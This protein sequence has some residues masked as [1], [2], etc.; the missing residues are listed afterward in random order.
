MRVYSVFK[1]S[2][3]A[4]GYPPGLIVTRFFKPLS[5]PSGFQSDSWY[6]AIKQKIEFILAAVSESDGR[7]IIASDTD[8]QFFKPFASLDFSAVLRSTGVDILFMREAGSDPV[9]VNAGFAVIRCTPAVAGLYRR[10]LS[11]IESERLPY[12]D[13]DVLNTEW[14]AGSVSIGVIPEDSVIWGEKLPAQP[15]Q[16]WFHH[17]VCCRT[18]S[19][20]LRQFA[21]VRLKVERSELEVEA[22]RARARSGYGRR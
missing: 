12:S 3:L 22:G 13:Q 2:L 1:S 6:H 7:V 17:A 14:R 15:F 5:G 4:I 10:V 18:V 8:I 20:K 9:G 16:A 21:A 11:R 19:E